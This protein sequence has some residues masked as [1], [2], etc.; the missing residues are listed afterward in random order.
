M[1]FDSSKYEKKEKISYPNEAYQ[2]ITDYAKYLRDK[3]PTKYKDLSK[4]EG[5]L[6]KDSLDAL[7]KIK[8]AYS[9]EFHPDTQK[10]KS[11]KMFKLFSQAHDLLKDYI[12][13]RGR[14]DPYG[15][16]FGYRTVQVINREDIWN[17]INEELKAYKPF[18]LDTQ[19]EGIIADWFRN[20]D[21]Y[22]DPSNPSWFNRSEE[23]TKSRADLRLNLGDF[24]G[25]LNGYALQAMETSFELVWGKPYNNKYVYDSGLTQEDMQ[26]I[27]KLIAEVD[28]EKKLSK[29]QKELKKQSKV[30]LATKLLKLRNALKNATVASYLGGIDLYKRLYFLVKKPSLMVKYLEKNKESFKPEEGLT[31]ERI[32]GFDFPFGRRFKGSDIFKEFDEFFKDFFR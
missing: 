31:I 13:A 6:K 26:T 28:K 29:S 1:P 17:K 27:N 15:V 5:V 32:L 8:R 19:L 3:D 21:P 22:Y 7:Q 2:L 23:S 20:F 11:D 10:D 16:D 18:N 25:A 9:M 30:V 24:Y 14:Y 12:E 4:L